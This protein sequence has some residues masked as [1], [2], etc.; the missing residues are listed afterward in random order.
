VGGDDEDHGPPEG[1]ARRQAAEL[2]VSPPLL[3][4]DQLGTNPNPNTN[5]NTKP[6]PNPKPNPHQ[7]PFDVFLTA[8][9]IAN[10]GAMAC[11][12]WG[13]EDNPAHIVPYN[14]CMT[15]FSYIYYVEFVFKITGLGPAQVRLTATRT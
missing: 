11:D 1:I 10:V 7:V 13:I 5:T 14:T 3:Q 12:Y 8:V 15:I 6:N 4:A 9:I 2:Q